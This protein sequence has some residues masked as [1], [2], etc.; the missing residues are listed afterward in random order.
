MSKQKLLLFDMMGVIF[1]K[2]RFVQT[3]H[4]LLPNIPKARIRKHYNLFSIGKINDIEFWKGLTN[5][6]IDVEEEFLSVFKLDRGTIPLLKKI[7]RKYRLAVFSNIPAKWC[8]ILLKRN[9]IGHFFDSMIFSC[10]TGLA[11]PSQNAFRTAV[12]I[13]ETEPHNI[14]FIDDDT[15][16]LS[17]AKRLGIITVWIKKE[18]ESFGFKPDYTISKL[19]EIE[20]IALS[21]ND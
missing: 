14:I 11:K 4:Q 8:N 17:V 2:G 7:R 13:L 16:N 15:R 1:K 21:K 18:K 20:W 5:D 19:S 3:L 6:P 12:A 9:N 10:D